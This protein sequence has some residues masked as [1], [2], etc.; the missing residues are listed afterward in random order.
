[1]DLAG[2]DGMLQVNFAQLHIV[3]V[4]M[5]FIT[6]LNTYSNGNQRLLISLSINRS[7]AAVQS[8]KQEW[9]FGLELP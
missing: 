3:Y 9:S 7:L 2:E 1:M 4:C 6:F 5:S 8:K